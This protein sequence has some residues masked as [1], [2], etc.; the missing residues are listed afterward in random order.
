M[1]GRSTETEGEVVIDTETDEEVVIETLIEGDI[2]AVSDCIDE[3]VNDTL[4][5][6]DTLL[7]S[8][9]DDV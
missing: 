6:D 2:D 9:D 5:V 4:L 7:V 3:L 8:L 1:V